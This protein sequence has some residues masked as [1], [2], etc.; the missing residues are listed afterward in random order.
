M[1]S[2]MNCPDR[3]FFRRI[4]RKAIVAVS[5]VLLFI[6]FVIICVVFII[7]DIIWSLADRCAN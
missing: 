7:I 2:G 6:L 3:M 5:S 4:I 1:R